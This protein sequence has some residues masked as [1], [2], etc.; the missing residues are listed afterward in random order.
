MWGLGL[1]MLCLFAFVIIGV[2]SNI[3]LTN[4]Q[5]Y[6]GVKQTTE[7]GAYDS[8]D[9]VVYKRGICLCVSKTT[10]T[11]GQVKFTSKTQ[12]TVREP[13]NDN[14]DCIE[15]DKV[16]SSSEK[17]ELMQGEYVLDPKVFTESVISRLGSII[18]PSEIYDITVQEV[19]PYPPKVSVNIEY[20]QA[21]NVDGK[22]T[23]GQIIPNKFDGIFEDTGAHSVL[24]YADNKIDDWALSCDS[25]TPQETTEETPQETTPGGPSSSDGCKWYYVGGSKTCKHKTQTVSD[26]H[27]GTKPKT[28]TVT[29]TGISPT[30]GTCGDA[31]QECVNKV[32]AACGSGWDYYSGCQGLKHYTLTLNADN[33]KREAT[34]MCSSPSVGNISYRG[35]K[36]K[37][38]QTGKYVYKSCVCHN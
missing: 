7:A 37:N 23:I 3:T 6:Y 17:C 10:D 38:K 26:E 28:K 13:I 24:E 11:S 22:D 30:K 4:Q 25:A 12:Y 19:I 29:I 16:D 34:E 36:N 32:K 15:P 18:K 20:K 8:V 2:I 31:Y 21:L 35:C 1:I 27:G 33:S 5:D 9:Q 14:N